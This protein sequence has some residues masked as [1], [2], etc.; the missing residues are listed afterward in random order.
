MNRALIILFLFF[1][2]AGHGQNIDLRILKSL[3]QTDL[4]CWDKTMRGVSFSVYP[5]MPLVA[6]GVWAHGYA[7]KDEAL[8]RSGYKSAI[9]ITFAVATTSGLKYLF[10]RQRPFKEYPNDIVQRDMH[11]GPFSFP[12]GHTTA[13]FASATAL[14]LSYKKWYVTLPSYLYAGFVGYSRMRLGV[15]YPSDVLGG[16]IIGIGAGLLTWKLDKMINHK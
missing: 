8:M 10:N 11:V 14:S 3:N 13:A 12:S 15:H 9:A 5:V 6:G 2:I 7:T 16:M 4:P 1:T